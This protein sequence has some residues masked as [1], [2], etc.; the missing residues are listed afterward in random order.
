MAA[1][2]YNAM[3]SA[4]GQSVQQANLRQIAEKPILVKPSIDFGRWIPY[5]LYRLDYPDIPY[6]TRQILPNEMVFDF[7]RDAWS[8]NAFNCRKLNNTLK[9]NNIPYWLAYSGGKG[10]HVHVFFD[11]NSLTID[12][13]VIEKAKEEL[14]DID[15]TVRVAIWN[16]IIVWAKIDRKEA[17][18]DFGK[19]NFNSNK[20]GSMLRDF[21]TPRDKSG[22]ITFK[23]L[24][25]EIPEDLPKPEDL[26]LV[27]PGAPVQW[28][29]SHL[30]SDIEKAIQN[31]TKQYKRSTIDV[32]LEGVGVSD[33]YCLQ[34][35]IKDGIPDQAP[36]YYAAYS[37]ARGCH[38]LGLPLEQADANV[39]AFLNQCNITEEDRQV[40]HDNALNG[41]DQDQHHLSCSSIKENYGNDFC[42]K[43]CAVYQKR[44]DAKLI[45]KGATT[46]AE[47]ELFTAM[48]EEFQG[49]LKMA[50]S[51]QEKHP[52][53]FD[54]TRSYWLWL[55]DEL[56]YIMVDETDILNAIHRVTKMNNLVQ[57]KIRSEILTAIQMT[58]RL[59]NPKEPDK[60][61]IQFLDYCV[62]IREKGTI[63]PTPEYLFTSRIPH[64]VGDTQ[65]TPYID[66]LFSDWV[67][68]DNKQV[69]YEICAFCMLQDYPIHRMFW[70]IGSGRNGKDRF[71]ELIQRLVGRDNCTS[72]DLQRITESRFES[73]KLYKKLVACIGET[74][75]GVL[76]KTNLLK[77]LTGASP[78]SGEYKNKT[79]F[80]FWNYAKIIIATN[81]VPIVEDKTDGWFQRNVFV[82]FPN[83]F[84]EGND[85][86]AKITETEYENLCRKCINIL[87]ELL[88]KG[89][90]TNELS[91]LEKRQEYE[92]KSNPIGQFIN[93]ECELDVNFIVPVWHLFER[94]T[95][96]LKQKG[97]RTY[98]K[99]A[100]RRELKGLDFDLE[101]DHFFNEYTKNGRWTAVLG[102]RLKNNPHVEDSAHSAQSALPNEEQPVGSADCADK[103]D[104]SHSEA[105]VGEVSGSTP[106]SPQSPQ[107]STKIDQ[108]IKF[109]EHIKKE[110]LNSTNID[111]F[112]SMFQVG[113]PDT[114]N[115]R[116]INYLEHIG[117]L[118]PKI[119]DNGDKSCII[120][121]K[122]GKHKSSRTVD[123]N[124]EVKEWRCDKCHEVYSMGQEVRP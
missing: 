118:T 90:F 1:N 66:K 17:K 124:T 49:P 3:V 10:L 89:K 50:E 32:S 20:K 26:P 114:T 8:D 36:V 74:D 86:L 85:I 83:K 15:K 71:I 30:T 112:V 54:K 100:F 35:L 104:Y 88:N 19:V 60:N 103:E 43:S 62:D 109:F 97:L 24:I 55:H 53:Y 94:I 58:G 123:R 108:S 51:M 23:T 92:N 70:L 40:R 96:Y 12:Q 65:D 57:G 14:V 81:S 45:E 61:W 27:F 42:N 75:H 121:G 93:E 119:K 11:T 25:E 87:P 9:N 82:E 113:N 64:K 39:T 7:D 34:K 95:V 76:K 21:G 28:D 29:V 111:E 48:G 77:A 18:L 67:G 98:S 44:S 101:S 38:D 122:P 4:K 69:L 16:K 120:C 68:A 13:D 78:I 56:R 73:S 79:P 59:L 72:T 2:Y 99:T 105:H 6:F 116:I 107:L 5:D 46:K 117:R 47:K 106:Q 110:V 115:D 63:E 91:L 33:V 84:G 41:Y 37:I 52:I 102:I 31:R 22:V 80:D